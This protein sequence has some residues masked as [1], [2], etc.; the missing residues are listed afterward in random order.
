MLLAVAGRIPCQGRTFKIS[1]CR[2]TLKTRISRHELT[3]A[4]SKTLKLHTP[5]VPEECKNFQ[6]RHLIWPLCNSA[7]N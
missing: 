2:Q 1:V 4:T 3:A 7:M 6:L 5:E